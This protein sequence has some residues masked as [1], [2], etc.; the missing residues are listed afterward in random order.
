MKMSRTNNVDA[1]SI[2]TNRCFNLSPTGRVSDESPGVSTRRELLRDGGCGRK[3]GSTSE[4]D[5]VELAL[6]RTVLDGTMSVCKGKGD[7]GIEIG[8][9]GSDVSAAIGDSSS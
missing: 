7:K 8:G 9:S 3:C 4:R 5:P 6:E 2:S 1:I